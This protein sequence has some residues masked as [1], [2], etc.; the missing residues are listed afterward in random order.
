MPKL[1]LTRRLADQRMSLKDMWGAWELL[2]DG[3][4]DLDI[5]GRPR[6]YVTFHGRRELC[7]QGL[8]RRQFIEVEINDEVELL[9]LYSR[10]H[11]KH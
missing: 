6:A 10:Y 4:S 3:P 9:E 11:L 1:W 8:N 2:P 5:A 7:W